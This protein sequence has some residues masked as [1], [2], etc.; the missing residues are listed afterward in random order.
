MLS[1]SRIGLLSS[2]LLCAAVATGC[3]DSEVLDCDPGETK[4]VKC[5]NESFEV[6]CG[7]DGAWPVT[8]CNT[9]QAPDTSGSLDKAK[10]SAILK[11][12][13]KSKV[14]LDSK[15]GLIWQRMSD[16]I[17][18][19]RA[20]A[21][22]YCGDLVIEDHQ[23]GKLTEWRLPQRDELETIVLTTTTDPAIDLEAFPDTP[24]APFWSRTLHSEEQKQGVGVDFKTGGSG[25]QYFTEKFFVRC[26]H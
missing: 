8:I 5:D 22:A 13:Q 18:R 2:V 3:G 4:Q 23:Y 26:V 1:K 19:N 25:Y 16:N 21:I 7:D 15:W 11:F 12:D 20:A 24:S 10:G 17:K 6:T 9:K 14:V